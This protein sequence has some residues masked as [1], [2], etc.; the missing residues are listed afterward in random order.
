MTSS[1]LLSA[2]MTLSLS[3]QS[4]CCQ[5]LRLCLSR[6]NHCVVRDYDSISL[7]SITVLSVTKTLALSCQSLCCQWLWLSLSDGNASSRSVVL[8]DRLLRALNVW[9]FFV[10]ALVKDCVFLFLWC[11]QL[12]RTFGCQ[13]LC[14]TVVMGVDVRF[15]LLLAVRRGQ[16]GQ[17]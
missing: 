6:V 3:C 16:D 1:T 9:E 8:G 7:V 12:C 15:L 11:Q 5:W 4:L 17:V 13:Q 2:T 14:R 10:F